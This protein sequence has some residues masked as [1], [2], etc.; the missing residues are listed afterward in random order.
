MCLQRNRKKPMGYAEGS[1]ED[2]ATKLHD[3]FLSQPRLLRHTTEARMEVGNTG[4]FIV[5]SH[6]L[7]AGFL[8]P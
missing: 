1:T 2:I 4:S 3:E 8:R 7:T 5:L 6:H